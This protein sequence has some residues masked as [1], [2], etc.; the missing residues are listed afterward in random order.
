MRL[1]LPGNRL[2][3][4]APGRNQAEPAVDPVALRPRLSPGLP[5]AGNPRLMWLFFIIHILEAARATTQ[6]QG[7]PATT[8]HFPLQ[9]S[10]LTL[11]HRILSAVIAIGLKTPP[12]ARRP[13]GSL[14]T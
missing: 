13:E 5:W 1:Q 12:A 8:H 11:N 7:K 14:Y 6:F 10:P 9:A 4:P 3:W 2:S